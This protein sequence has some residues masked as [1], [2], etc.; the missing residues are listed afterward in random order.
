[1]FLS[2]SSEES[3]NDDSESNVSEVLNLKTFQA[4]DI[5]PTTV[6]VSSLVESD[7]EKSLKSRGVCYNTLGNPTIN[8]FKV[9][10]SESKIGPYSTLL[11]GLEQNSKFYAKLY[12]VSNSGLVYYGNE[13]TFQTSKIIIVPTQFITY[14]ATNVTFNF[15]VLGGVIVK[16]GNLRWDNLKMGICF[17]ATNKTPNIKDSVVYAKT[18]VT[19]PFRISAKNLNSK[20]TYYFRPFASNFDGTETYYGD[21]QTFT[22]TNSN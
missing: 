7:T 13:I 19:E 21:I 8:D 10:D 17:S 1:M 22:T 9:E 6:L 14:E 18:E 2:C 12:A 16:N 20:T 3:K 4:S 11:I 5:M 15:A